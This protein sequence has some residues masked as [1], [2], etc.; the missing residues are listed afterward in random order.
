MSNDLSLYSLGMICLIK[1]Y[2]FSL[3]NIKYTDRK[4][5]IYL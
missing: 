4:L 2:K 3:Q 5:K 1:K